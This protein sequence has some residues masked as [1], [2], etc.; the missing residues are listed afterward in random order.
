M[1]VRKLNG[2]SITLYNIFS[3]AQYMFSDPFKKLSGK[4]FII[5]TG[6]LP[7][8]TKNIIT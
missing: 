1:Q 8:L 3:S 6:T 4:T 7:A 5:K 2:E